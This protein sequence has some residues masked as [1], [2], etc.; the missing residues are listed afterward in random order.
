MLRRIFAAAFAVAALLMPV[1][2]TS[3]VADEYGPDEFPCT[4]ELRSTVIVEGSTLHAE[5][6]CTEDASGT[7]FLYTAGGSD[8]IDEESFTIAAGSSDT[9]TIDGLEAG[10]Y[11]LDFN[12]A[13]GGDLAEEAAFTVTAVAPGTD[14][15]TDPGDGLAA[16]GPT[17]MPYLA[18]AGALLLAGIAAIVVTRRARNR[19]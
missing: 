8:V 11:V 2:A 14:G 13:D 10:D 18:T 4:I 6:S 1:G 12:D 17:S 15:G 7:L 5:I 3:A 16:T 9:F 19:A